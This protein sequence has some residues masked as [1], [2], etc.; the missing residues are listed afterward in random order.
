MCL[1]KIPQNNIH[2]HSFKKIAGRSPCFLYHAPHGMVLPEGRDRDSDSGGF[3]C[4]SGAFFEIQFLYVTPETPTR[5]QR[6]LSA[7]RL[8]RLERLRPLDYGIIVLSMYAFC[9]IYTVN[10]HQIDRH[11]VGLSAGLQVKRVRR[12]RK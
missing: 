4:L 6:L 3:P 11:C 12:K 8:A 10:L 5:N 7:R 2:T 9:G 1:E